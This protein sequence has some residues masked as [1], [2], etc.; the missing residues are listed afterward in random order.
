MRRTLKT[1]LSLAF[2]IIVATVF[3]TIIFSTGFEHGMLTEAL[4]KPAIPICAGP[5]DEEDTEPT[6]YRTVSQ[7]QPLPISGNLSTIE[8]PTVYAPRPRLKGHPPLI[9][10]EYSIAPNGEAHILAPRATLSGPYTVKLVI[11]E[12]GAAPGI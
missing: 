2:G 11:E 5:L 4:Q 12:D 7:E 3:S 6:L 1:S 9:T 8:L 10:P